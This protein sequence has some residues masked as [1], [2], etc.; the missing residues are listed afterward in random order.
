MPNMSRIKMDKWNEEQGSLNVLRYFPIIPRLQRLFLSKD[1]STQT[2]WH[3]VYLKSDANLLRHPADGD[4]WKDFDE[5]YPDFAL[6]PRNLRLG[7][8][9]DGF[10]P[11]GN[12]T[13]S[14]SM[15]PLLVIPYNL[16]PMQCTDQ[17]NCLMALLI[18]GPKSPAKDFDVFM[19]PLIRDLQIL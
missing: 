14:Y 4:A 11:F 1:T 17:S 2:K 6:D 13:N 8:A 5:K 12:M 18:P 9:T 19:Q 15:W 3:K 7:L 16:P 10:N